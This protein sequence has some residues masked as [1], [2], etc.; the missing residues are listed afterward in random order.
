MTQTRFLEA[1]LVRRKPGKRTASLK[2]SSV[3]LSVAKV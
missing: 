3:I 1:P 2:I